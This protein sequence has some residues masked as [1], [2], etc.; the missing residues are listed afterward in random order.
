MRIQFARH[1][2][3]DR[4]HEVLPEQFRQSNNVGRRILQMHDIRPSNRA[5]QVFVG[6]LAKL[7]RLVLQHRLKTRL[8]GKMLCLFETKTDLEIR[9]LPNSCRYSEDESFNAAVCA[10]T[11][12]DEK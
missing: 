4:E 10:L 7:D 2:I 11:R 3:M 6:A 12:T 8:P 1:V 9:V 5:R